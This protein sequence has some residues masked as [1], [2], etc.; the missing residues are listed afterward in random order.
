MKFFIKDFF[1]KCYQIRRKLWILSHLLKKSLVENFIFCPMKTQKDIL[2][3]ALIYSKQIFL[4]NIKWRR[5][6]IFYIQ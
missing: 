3:A 2:N 1:C 4:K 6:Y 5:S